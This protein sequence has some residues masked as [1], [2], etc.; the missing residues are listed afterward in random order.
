MMQ[1]P[2]ATAAAV[3]P[4]IRSS[5]ASVTQRLVFF[6]NLRVVAMAM[7]ILQHVGQ[8]YGPTGGAWLIQEPDKAVVLSPFFTVNRSF[9]MSL[10]FMIAGY[11]MVVSCDR[12]GAMPFLK[13]RALRLGLPLLGWCVFMEFLQ[14][15]VFAVPA[16]G[17]TRGVVWPVEVAHMWFVEHLL[18]YSAIYAGWRL[19][20][21]GRTFTG[22]T[23]SRVPPWWAIA[24]F[25]LV[26]ALVS[27]AVRTWYPIDHWVYLLGFIKVAW[28]DVPRD[29]SFFIIGAVAYRQGW[30]LGFSSRAGRIW[31]GTG[32]LLAALWYGYTLA[33]P[34]R[35]F[36]G[37][38][39]GTLPH[40]IWESLLCMSM[41]IG[42]TVVF[43]DLWNR[44][45][46]L[47]KKMARGQYATYVFHIGVVLLFQWALMGLAA[48]PFV[49][50]VLASLLSV[51]AAFM[52]GYWVRKPLRL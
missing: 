22:S 14:A 17:Y 6:D 34:Q 25:A 4:L 9:G 39:L 30:L 5:A 27:F 12:K 3:P 23:P 31:L 40:A 38:A 47:G 33:M 13:D 50:F 10:F 52:L 43:R 15:F 49:K 42:L 19:L 2:I 45:S 11:F 48:A 20:R 7:V 41:C 1:A 44:Q 24:A 21:R 51:P 35:A 16:N 18:I 26:L 36:A 46:V 37:E 8:A 28:A 32:V 29:L